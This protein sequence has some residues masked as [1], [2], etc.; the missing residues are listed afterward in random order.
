MSEVVDPPKAMPYSFQIHQSS[1]YDEP[2]AR[3][4]RNGRYIP[5]LQGKVK[6][7]VYVSK[8]GTHRGRLCTDRLEKLSRKVNRSG[9]DVPHILIIGLRRNN[10]IGLSRIKKIGEGY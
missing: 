3:N 5:D 7:I 9:I 2:S 10:S 4:F 8:V 1:V 6:Y